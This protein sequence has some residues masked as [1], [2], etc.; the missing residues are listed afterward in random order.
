MP[1]FAVEKRA[2]H[3]LAASVPKT[4]PDGDRDVAE[5]EPVRNRTSARLPISAHPSQNSHKSTMDC[6]DEFF[7]ELYSFG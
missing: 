6:L 1:H 7:C 4:L 5:I 2:E 3:G